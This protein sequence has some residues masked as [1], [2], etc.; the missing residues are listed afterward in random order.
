MEII[1]GIPVKTIETHNG[2]FYGVSTDTVGEL[3]TYA[4]NNND[5]LVNLLDETA[6]YYVPD[7]IFQKSE[8]EIL[9]YLIENVDSELTEA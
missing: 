6:Q 5:G 2:T 3:L 4:E 7:D 8:I 9:N 1:N